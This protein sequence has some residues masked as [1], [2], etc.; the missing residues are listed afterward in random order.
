MPKRPPNGSE[1]MYRIH[2]ESRQVGDHG[3]RRQMCRAEKQTHGFWL[4]PTWSPISIGG[5]RETEAE[6]R[7]DIDEYD[8]AL[9]VDVIVFGQ[10][11][12]NVVG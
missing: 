10:T 12:S 11:R 6:A 5:W 2:W 8:R 1:L 7:R 9:P 3:E 4:F